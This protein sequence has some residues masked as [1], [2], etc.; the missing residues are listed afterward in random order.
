MCPFLATGQYHAKVFDSTF[1]M[2][3]T[4]ERFV[5]EVAI[6][7]AH[8]CCWLPYERIFSIAT[9]SMPASMKIRP[10]GS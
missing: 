10:R 3:R 6:S 2:A 4:G 1:L 8:P 9:C 5:T 7:A